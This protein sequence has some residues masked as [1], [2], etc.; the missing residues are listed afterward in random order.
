LAVI[1]SEPSALFPDLPTIATSGVPGYESVGKTVMLA[2]AKTPAAIIRR[3]NQ[4][5]VKALNVQDMKM[6]FLNSGSEV[7][8]SSPEQLAAT[9]KSEMTR[10]GNLIKDA[11]IKAVP[12]NIRRRIAYFS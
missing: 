3:L 4:E 11:G 12:Q 8:G 9:M 7:V 1:S 2:P 6:R 10:I 5:V